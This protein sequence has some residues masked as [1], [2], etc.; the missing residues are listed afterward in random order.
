MAT[1][2]GTLKYRV[3]QLEKC[4]Q[5]TEEKLDKILNNHLPHINEQIAELRT[6]VKLTAIINAGAIVLGLLVSKMIL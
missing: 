2:G 5:Q 3:E 6:T 4:Q 1:N